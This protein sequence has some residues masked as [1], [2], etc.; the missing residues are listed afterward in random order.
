MHS[1]D[2]SERERSLDYISGVDMPLYSQEPI[3]FMKVTVNDHRFRSG[4]HQ[5]ST[6]ISRLRP[7]LV[8][9]HSENVLQST[10]SPMVTSQ[11]DIEYFTTRWTNLFTLT[12][13]P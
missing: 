11:N 5:E 3:S 9:A 4:P 6:W 12:F 10:S 7:H 2:Q 8:P 13:I 1:D